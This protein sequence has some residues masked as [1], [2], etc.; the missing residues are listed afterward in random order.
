MQP[1]LRE[2]AKLAGVSRG[3]VDRVIHGRGRVDKTVEKRI[4]ALMEQMGYKP[5]TVSRNLV[6]Q[7]QH[8]KL[9]L[10]CR[11]DI[12]GFWE[13]LL[14]GVDAIASELAEYNVTVLRRYFNLFIPEE[15]IALID[16]L[17]HAGI[18]GLVIVPLND[19]RVRDRLRKLQAK[20]ITV[21]IINSELEGFEPFCYIGSD[22]SKAGRTAAGLLH[23]LAAR[24]HTH[25][26]IL[27]GRQ[28]MLSHMQRI[29]GFTDELARL[30]TPH[31]L[32]GQFDITSDPNF[33]YETMVALFKR[34]PE[35]N[36]VYT[37][38]GNGSVCRVIQDLDLTEKIIHISFDLTPSTRQ[39]L[40]DGNLT[41]CIGQEAY[42]QGYQPLKILFN[43]L[44][45]GIN[46]ES[47][48]ILTHNEIFIRQNCMQGETLQGSIGQTQY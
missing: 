22:Y 43:Y 31:T 38:A 18:S 10:I 13:E 4:L 45:Y 8:L 40:M 28:Y 19:D 1:T 34:Y 21:L 44:A 2:I 36:A 26:M 48:Q 32:I 6:I 42:R 12:N 15:Q 37:V 9:G 47:R 20:G 16:E 7:K 14:T 35:T 11:T 23:I 24:Q 30:K 17:E 39:K 3:T 29:Q 5:N 25:L 41:V 46:P 33:A 27:T